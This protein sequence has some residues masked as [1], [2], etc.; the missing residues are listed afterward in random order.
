[1]VDS[2]LL[3]LKLFSPRFPESHQI[4]LLLTVEKTAI[5]TVNLNCPNFIGTFLKG[6]GD[7]RRVFFGIDSLILSPRFTMPHGGDAV[8][9]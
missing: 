3:N 5:A 7:F 1:M 9:L 6:F 2:A 4:S 8:G